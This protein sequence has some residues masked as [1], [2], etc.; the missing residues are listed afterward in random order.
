MLSGCFC[1]CTGY[2]KPIRAVLAA[3]AAGR[4]SGN[5]RRGRSPK[6]RAARAG[7]R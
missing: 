6:A 2:E 1:R 5:G 4:T 7:K 3:A